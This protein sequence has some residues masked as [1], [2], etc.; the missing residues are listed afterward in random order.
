MQRL[1]LLAALLISVASFGQRSLRYQEL[2]F[3]I[4][5][6]NYNGEVSSAPGVGN[7]LKEMGPYLALDYTHYFGPRFGMGLRLGYGIASANDLNHA[8]PD[9]GLSFRSDV[10]ELNG[11][12]ILNL[13]KYGK[14]HQSRRS[15]LYLKA[16]GGATWVHP[17]LPE[18]VQFNDDVVLYPGTTG[19]FNLGLGGGIKWRLSEHSALNLEFMG[20]YLFSDVME[21]FKLN[22]DNNG[23]DGYGGFRLG[24]S[25][26][27]H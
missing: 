5:T 4:G 22:S 1:S 27:F 2:Q 24:Y 10:V 18:D 14:Y 20:H 7:W 9:R 12:L 17:T 16:S 8:T 25:V 15:T 11:Q 13:A 21:G 6:M 26:Y 23:T 3:N 19:G